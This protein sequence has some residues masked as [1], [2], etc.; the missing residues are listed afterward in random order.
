MER[1]TW[2]DGRLDDLS[3]RV[4]AGFEQVDRRFEQVDQRF[5]RVDHELRD[6]RIEVRD[7]FVALGGRIDSLYYLIVG[8]AGAVIVCLLGAIVT[9]VLRG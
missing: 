3:K 8:F 6:L 2:N 1:T 5:E 9:L 4:D 7:G